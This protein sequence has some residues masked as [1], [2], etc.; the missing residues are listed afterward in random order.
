VAIK[1]ERELLDYLQSCKKKPTPAGIWSAAIELMEAK[2]SMPPR[3]VCPGDYPQM[4][5]GLC[6][7]CTQ[8]GCLDF[9]K[10]KVSC[11]E[12]RS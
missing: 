7:H 4:R 8:V 12:F 10:N 2:F 5:N 3:R 11:K 1:Y 6:G 9:S